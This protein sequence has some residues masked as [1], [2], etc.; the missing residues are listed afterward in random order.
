MNKTIPEKNYVVQKFYVNCPNENCGQFLK[1]MHRDPMLKIFNSVV[2]PYEFDQFTTMGRCHSCDENFQIET[3]DVVREGTRN[4][5]GLGAE[6]W[7]Y[8]SNMAKEMWA[9]FL[10]SE[11]IRNG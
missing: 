5:R 3:P 11:R 8:E 2:G 7:V 1:P 9:E 4:V 10:Q 6:R